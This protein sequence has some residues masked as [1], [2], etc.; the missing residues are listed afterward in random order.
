MSLF[1]SSN[2]KYTRDVSIKNIFLISIYPYIIGFLY[3]A[4]NGRNQRYSIMG[5]AFEFKADK[6]KNLGFYLR[7]V[8]LLIPYFNINHEIISKA[9]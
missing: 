1:D 8:K 4:I 5:M 6:I 2:I 9:F 3:S 7:L